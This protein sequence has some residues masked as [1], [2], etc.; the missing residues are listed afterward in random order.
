MAR[1]AVIGKIDSPVRIDLSSE[2]NT[3]I[4]DSVVIEIWSQETSDGR[5]AK[6]EKD[7]IW[8]WQT[9]RWT[10]WPLLTSA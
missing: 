8:V 1:L 6:E 3:G 7:W 9:V 10:D 5:F 4:F 2:W